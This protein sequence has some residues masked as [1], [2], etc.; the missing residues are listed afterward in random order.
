MDLQKLL[1][2]TSFLNKFQKVKRSLYVTGEDRAENDSEHSYQLAMTAWYVINSKGLNYDLD[3]I[4]KY[5]LAHDLVEVYA[6]DTYCHTEDENLKESKEQ[7]E[8]ESFERVSIEFNEFPELLKC[9]HDYEKKS[10]KEALFIYALDKILPPLNIYLDGG[11]TW[12][13]FE[14]SIVDDNARG[15]NKVH[16][17]MLKSKN[18][19]VAKSPDIMKIWEDLYLVLED[20]EEELFP[21][22]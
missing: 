7:R 12:K 4:F 11:R 3:K 13:G 21:G 6:G 10:D 2:F 9:I 18:P 5:A 15:S 19:K 20:K 8:M 17:E 16:L 22:K 14:A 1:E